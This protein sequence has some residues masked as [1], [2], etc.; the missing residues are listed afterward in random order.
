MTK[1]LIEVGRYA[2]LLSVMVL[3]TPGWASLLT[4]EDTAGF[5]IGNGHS[6]L[7][8][9][10]FEIG[11]GR[12]LIEIFNADGAHS[13]QFYKD[14][15]F[16]LTGETT[17]ATGF[18]AAGAAK[19]TLELAVKRDVSIPT[20]SDFILQGLKLSQ[21]AVVTQGSLQG[22]RKDSYDERTKLYHVD[23][24]LHLA[25]GA[26]LALNIESGLQGLK[27]IQAIADSVKVYIN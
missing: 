27:E 26:V 22:F 9:G 17:W 13:I 14:F 18:L 12:E 23:L 24:S 21:G 15:D 6:G 20:L 2:V 1:R 4:I 11:N 8:T 5:E 10:G 25:Q 19:A 7:D 3:S 16:Q